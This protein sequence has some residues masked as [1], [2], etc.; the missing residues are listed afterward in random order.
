MIEIE[1]LVSHEEYFKLFPDEIPHYKEYTKPRE[2]NPKSKFPSFR[3][4]AHGFIKW[5]DEDSGIWGGPFPGKYCLME[6][7]KYKN[8]QLRSMK[9]IEEE[10]VK[11]DKK[12]GYSSREPRNVVFCTSK[13]KPYSVYLMG[14]DDASY[15]KVYG[16]KTHAIRAIKNL[17][18]NPTNTNLLDIEKFVFTN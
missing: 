10:N 9:E 2:Y 3:V 13:E 4:I 5:N 15:T 12:Y 14:N 18:N 17:I 1:N 11:L 16:T 7:K 6:L 8:P